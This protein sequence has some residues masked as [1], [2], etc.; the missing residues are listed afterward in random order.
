M[1]ANLSRIEML[2]VELGAAVEDARLAMRR[3]EAAAGSYEHKIER[4]KLMFE[5]ADRLRAE[6]SRLVGE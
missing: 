2:L 6:V 5:H 4:A 3:V 1:K